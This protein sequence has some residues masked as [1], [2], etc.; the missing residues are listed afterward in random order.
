MLTV[1]VTDSELAL[2]KDLAARDK[3]SLSAAVRAALVKA[4]SAA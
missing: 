1:A 3:T 4:A 2:A